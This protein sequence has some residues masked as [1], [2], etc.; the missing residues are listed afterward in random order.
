M[1]T[2]AQTKRMI[3]N[4]LDVLDIGQFPGYAAPVLVESR[5]LLITMLKD[6]EHVQSN[7]EQQSNVNS[8]QPSANEAG[9]GG[10]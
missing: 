6:L 8:D 10:S 2:A 9:V 5:N 4:L 1:D 3:G 7:F